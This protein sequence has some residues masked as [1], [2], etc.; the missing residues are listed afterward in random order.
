MDIKTLIDN[1]KLATKTN[2]QKELAEYFG[3]PKS[4]ISAWINRNAVGA[5]VDNLIAAEREDLVNIIFCGKTEA[6]QE[7]TQIVAHPLVAEALKSGNNRKIAEVIADIMFQLWSD[8]QIESAEHQ[9]HV[10]LSKSW[11]L[12]LPINDLTYPSAK[13]QLNALKSSALG[14]FASDT[15]ERALKKEFLEKL[16]EQYKKDKI[17]AIIDCYEIEKFVRDI[18]KVTAP[19]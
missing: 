18:S 5:L 13:R 14:D 4:N 9:Y 17:D 2:T 16:I 11:R 7:L 6:A 15:E 3:W 12:E 1:L 8:E 10:D 19:N